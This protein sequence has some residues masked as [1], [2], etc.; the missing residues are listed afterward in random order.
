L[1]VLDAPAGAAVDVACDGRGCPFKARSFGV[2]AS[3]DVRLKRTF[4]RR[5]RTGAKLE[6][7]ITAPNAVG[8]VVRYKMRR[9]RLPRIWRLCVP[10]GGTKPGRC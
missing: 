5:L 4:T 7:R 2:G 9:D 10:P 8:K 1:R 3:G 6:I